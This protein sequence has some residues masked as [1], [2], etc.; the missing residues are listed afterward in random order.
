[1][2]AKRKEAIR[3]S[4]TK[5]QEEYI[6]QM[7]E[8]FYPE[9]VKGTPHFIDNGLIQFST[10]DEPMH[11]F[12]FLFYHLPDRMFPDSHYWQNRF[13]TLNVMPMTRNGNFVEFCYEF[14]N[15]VKDKKN[16]FEVTSHEF[17]NK[18]E[19]KEKKREENKLKQKEAKKA[20]PAK[21]E[22]AKVEDAKPGFE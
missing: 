4:I 13:Y 20:K 1:M 9:L 16:L 14:Y 12:E 22:D 18:L 5:T 17:V 15:K 6:L 21:V 19:Q 2:K 8:F 7:F 3:L 11:W 10:E